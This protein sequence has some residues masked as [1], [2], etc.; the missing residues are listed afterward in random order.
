LFWSVPTARSLISSAGTFL[1]WPSCS[2][3]NW[4]GISAPSALSNTARR[5]TVPLWVLT[6][7]STS[8]RK[9]VC[10]V[11][12]PSVVLICTGI[13][14][15]RARCPAPPGRPARALATVASSASKLA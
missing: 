9:P 6:W 13:W 1:A 5:R 8:C 11:A 7:L 15:M 14:S 10:G 3:A 4:P 12:S 2:W